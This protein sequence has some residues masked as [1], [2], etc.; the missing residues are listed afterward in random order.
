MSALT[1]E[2]PDADAAN[3]P[4]SVVVPTFNR[5]ERLARVLDGFAAQR[6]DAVFEVVVVSDGSSDGTD[7]YLRSGQTPLPVVA[8][9]Q[10]N[11]GPA[12]A[13]NSGIA[14]ARGA[15]V[16]FVDDDVIPEPGL[17]AAHLSAHAAND[18]DV[19]VIGPM[20]T[21]RDAELSPWIT[22]EQ[23][24]LDKQYALLVNLPNAHY[25]NFYTGNASMSR[26]RVVELGGFDKRF[27]R[28]EDIELA[29]RMYHAGMHFVFEPKA[30][31]LHYAQR[32]YESWLNNAYEY[33]RN[34]VIF[35]REGQVGTLEDI[36]SNFRSRHPLQ[37]WVVLAGLPRPRLAKV[38]TGALRR[39]ALVASKLNARM[40]ARQS[41]SGLYGL[42]YHQGVADELGGAALART[43]LLHGAQPAA[44]PEAVSR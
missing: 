18:G 37:R 25:R 40:I 39:T 41:L 22:W 9:F 23:A 20:L 16:L 15:L 24:M 42:R 17:V 21:P 44:R 33:G 31:G 19:V 8:V 28:A 38:L 30:R 6:D 2:T 10:P 7:E 5:R 43:L 34:D 14:A 27:R 11:S 36:S 35:A 1:P 32:S 29:Y 12:A 13:R 4:V 3:L 26:R